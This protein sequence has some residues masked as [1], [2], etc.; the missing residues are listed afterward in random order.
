MAVA[1][2]GRA[3]VVHGGND[4]FVLDLLLGVGEALKPPVLVYLRERVRG[5]VPACQSSEGASCEFRC[6]DK[7]RE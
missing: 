6:V 2:A 3:K 1:D 5:N 7:K 4:G